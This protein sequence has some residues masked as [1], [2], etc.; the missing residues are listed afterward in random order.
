MDNNC[1]YLE[2]LQARYFNTAGGFTTSGPEVLGVSSGAVISQE[3]LIKQDNSS[4]RPY[5]YYEANPMMFIKTTL[6]KPPNFANVTVYVGGYNKPDGDGG[7]FDDCIHSAFV[8]GVDVVGTYLSG[9]SQKIVTKDCFLK[10]TLSPT[11]KPSDAN[12]VAVAS[13]LLIFMLAV[14]LFGM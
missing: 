3:M 9:G 14:S 1:I 2:F 5:L 6:V 7:F 4:Q 11:T 12:L 13:P 8:N 10:P